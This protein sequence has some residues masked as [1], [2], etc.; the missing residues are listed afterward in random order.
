MRSVN[1]CLKADA[2]A[3]KLFGAGF[4]A[5]FLAPTPFSARR[6]ALDS[7]VFVAASLMFGGG[8]AARTGAKDLKN[9]KPGAIVTKAIM[10]TKNNMCVANRRARSLSSI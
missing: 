7:S 9:A 5:R 3:G 8:G 2:C 1:S 6:L 4:S 10:L